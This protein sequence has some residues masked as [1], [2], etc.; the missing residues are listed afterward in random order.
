MIEVQR[1]SERA[2]FEFEVVV[3]DGSGETRHCVT[4]SRATYERL[5]AGQ[6]TQEQCVEPGF[7]FLLDRGQKRRYSGASS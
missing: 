2:P 6:H 1:T 5:T 7:Y 4:V 3:R